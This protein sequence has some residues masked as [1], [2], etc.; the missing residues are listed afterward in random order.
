[1]LSAIFGMQVTDPNGTDKVVVYACAALYGFTT[2]M[3]VY[4]WC[5]YNYRPIKA[6]N[7]VWVSLMHLSAVLWFIGNIPTN[8]HVA[9]VGVWS[10][11][12]LWVIWLRI[13]F[14]F[15]FATL[16]IIRFYALD[17]VFNQKKPF[18]TWG[19]AI[20]FVAVIVFSV[21]FCLVNQL[22]DDSKT[23][24]YVEAMVVCNVT[25]GFRIAA[26][27]VQWVLWTGVG[28]LIFR[29]RNIQSSFNESRESIAIFV[30]AI[31][32][33]IESTVTY[34]HYKYFVLDLGQRIQ[35][36]VIDAVCTNLIIWLI[37][38]YPVF[39]S[40]FCRRQYEQKWMATLARD[41]HPKPA[42]RG[43][44]APKESRFGDDGI[45]NSSF[46]STSQLNFGA[47]DTVQGVEPF[48]DAEL[49]DRSTLRT[50][51]TLDGQEPRHTD[52]RLPIAMR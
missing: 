2:A 41:N 30:V 35:K 29:L 24:E 28:F 27:T 26:L 17:R 21:V 12:K 39:M 16:M 49:I 46:F 3:L 15:V 7:L 48:G 31:V 11:C 22:I 36:T 25:Q 42:P 4:A 34:I 20:A 10:K 18:T 37:I 52:D 45:G 1:L 51:I 9:L 33:L 19:S 8:G 13:L 44:V 23:V 47:A 32:L 14:C 43:V 40:I 38:A 6:K 50:D 5:N